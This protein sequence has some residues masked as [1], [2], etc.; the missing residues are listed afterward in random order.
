MFYHSNSN[1]NKDSDL[2]HSRRYEVK[3][4]TVSSTWMKNVPEASMSAASWLSQE[5]FLSKGKGLVCWGVGDTP[6]LVAQ[7]KFNFRY[8]FIILVCPESSARDSD[9]GRS[10]VVSTRR[11]LRIE[12]M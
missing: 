4:V 2:A 6:L 3:N 5:S 8:A 1:P 11:V 10:V 7:V 9:Q 12:Q